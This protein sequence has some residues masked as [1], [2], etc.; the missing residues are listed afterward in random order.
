MA[1]P[2]RT[3]HFKPIKLANDNLNRYSDSLEPSPEVE[4]II[5]DNENLQKIEPSEES[6]YI[7]LDNPHTMDPPEPSHLLDSENLSTYEKNLLSFNWKEILLYRIYNSIN[8]F[9]MLFGRITGFY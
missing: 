7:N 6:K 2:T 8:F 9:K 4:P 3:I 1:A 5:V